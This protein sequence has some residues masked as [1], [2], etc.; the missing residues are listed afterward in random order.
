MR[1]RPTPFSLIPRALAFIAAIVAVVAA[2]VDSS[3]AA[4]S[5]AEMKIGRVELGFKNHFKV[6]CWTPV[7]VEVAGGQVG[8]KQ[9]VEVTVGDSDGVPTTASAPLT[10]AAGSGGRLA[11]VYTNVG[12]VGSAIQ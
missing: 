7:R 4:D 3:I 6:G 9:R 10:A 11:T 8:E 1:Q 12:R 2:S 5:A